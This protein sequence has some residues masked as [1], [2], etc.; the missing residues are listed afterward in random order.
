MADE[1]FDNV[2]A[3][4]V[5]ENAVHMYWNAEIARGAETVPFE[6]LDPVRRNEVRQ[7][8]MSV[9][10][11]VIKALRELMVSRARI[12]VPDVIPDYFY[13]DNTK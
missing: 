5:V 10:P 6:E 2:D 13:G 9:A 3:L 7:R 4:G 8:V 12:E 1:P 11:H